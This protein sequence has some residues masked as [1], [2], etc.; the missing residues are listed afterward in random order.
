MELTAMCVLVVLIACGATIQA[1]NLRN[2]TR[3]LLQN[4]EQKKVTR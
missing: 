2:A 3:V 1:K 4:E